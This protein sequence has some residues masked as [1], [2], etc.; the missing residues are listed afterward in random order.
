MQAIFCI[1]VI[2][3][4]LHPLSFMQIEAFSSTS[5]ETPPYFLKSKE[6]N[7]F[8]QNQPEQPDRQFS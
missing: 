3:F 8:R 2:D 5:Q 6:G 7:S 4:L 1:C